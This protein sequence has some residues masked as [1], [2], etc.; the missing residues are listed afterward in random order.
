MLGERLRVF[1]GRACRKRA[2]SWAGCGISQPVQIQRLI[3]FGSRLSQESFQTRSSFALGQDTLPRILVLSRKKK[4]RE[5][6]NLDLFVC[7][8]GFTH[9]DNFLGGR[10]H[11]QLL[12]KTDSYFKPGPRRSMKR[13]ASWHCHHPKRVEFN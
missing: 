9:P 4:P 6:C 11:T 13:G 2:R 5:I 10:S 1:E 3:T 12:P 7:R 8:Q